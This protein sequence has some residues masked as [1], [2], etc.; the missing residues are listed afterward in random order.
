LSKP[1]I[2]SPYLVF[3]PGG[4]IRAL[5]ILIVVFIVFAISIASVLVLDHFEA[6]A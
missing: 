2:G 5:G 3:I 1:K 6:L 4:I